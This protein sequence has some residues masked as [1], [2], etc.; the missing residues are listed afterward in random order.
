MFDEIPAGLHQVTEKSVV[1]LGQGPIRFEEFLDM[2]GPKDFVELVDGVVEE[3]PMVQLDHGKL[4]GWLFHTL[5][6]IAEARKLGMV[7]SSR[8]AVKT[9]PFGSRLPDLFFVR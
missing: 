7:L 4:L 9:G 3:K 8:S 6:L 5:A 1:L 2:F